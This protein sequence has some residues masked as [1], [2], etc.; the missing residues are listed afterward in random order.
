M[1]PDSSTVKPSRDQFDWDVFLS[2]RSAD[3]D[4]V[5]RVA[6][7]LRSKQL[8]VWWDQ[9]EVPPGADFQ[10]ALWNGLRKSWATAVFVGP[11]T[12]SGWQDREVKEAINAQVKSGKPVLPVFLPGIPNPD[13][14]DLEFLG[15]NSRVVFGG[16]LD[17]S[18]VIDRMVWGIT[19]VNPNRE[20]PRAEPRRDEAQ[21]GAA[22]SQAISDLASW[23]KT[24]NVTFFVGPSATGETQANPPRNWEIALRL[25]RDIKVIDGDQVQLLP[26]MDIAATLYGI[27]ESD[28]VLESRVVDMIQS[29]SSKVPVPQARLGELMALLATRTIPRGKKP[30]KQLLLTMNID[31]MMERALLGAGVGFT[32]VVQH[33]SERKLYVT[34]F[35]GEAF[36]GAGPE[37][38]D[39]LI[40]R[41]EPTTRLPDEVAGIVLQEPIL[42]KLRGSLDIVGSCA[43]TRPQLLAQ[44]RMVIADRLIPAE[45]QKIAANTP[46]VFLGV[47]VLDPEFQYMSHT[48]LFGV[49]ESDHRKHL[50]QLAPG[51]DPEDLFRRVEAGLWSKMKD[52]ALRRNLATI[53]EP[54][55]RFLDRLTGA[56]GTS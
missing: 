13:A 56:L 31:L 35:H 34:S 28:P 30:Q 25:L 43:L 12:V 52:S 44:A 8:R 3:I 21:D 5:R 11:S 22:A 26:S 17:D 6:E 32:R 49:W 16:T 45:L 47:G 14:V 24:D 7:V 37:R 40:E 54:C 39:E 50:V 19:G 27:A 18:T 10:T 2:Y 38:I 36:K 46:I 41:T 29:R 4:P 15:L 53:E 55:G 9:W 23:L 48:V 33:K 42:F 1:P 51:Q 20:V